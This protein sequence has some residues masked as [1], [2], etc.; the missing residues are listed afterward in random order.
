[1]DAIKSY[2]EAISSNGDFAKN[3]ETFGH[4]SRRKSFAVGW[5]VVF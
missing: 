4:V 3:F 2:R 5:R 1:V